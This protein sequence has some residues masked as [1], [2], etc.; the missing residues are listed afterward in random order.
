MVRTLNRVGRAFFVEL[1][2]L[3]PSLMLATDFLSR[4]EWNG[5]AQISLFYGTI[6]AVLTGTVVVG[7][8][9]RKW[10]DHLVSDAPRIANVIEGR[11]MWGVYIFPSLVFLV[12]WAVATHP[13]H[14]T[15]IGRALGWA[16]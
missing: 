10:F 4:R 2:I 5:M 8:V 14:L 15:M 16:E 12:L 7:V 3:F 6:F 9:F 13:M 1:M 11:G